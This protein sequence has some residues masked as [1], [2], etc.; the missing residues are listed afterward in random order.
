MEDRRFIISLVIVLIGG[1]VIGGL[2]YYRMKRS[3]E[4]GM[5]A[6]RHVLSEEELRKALQTLTAPTQEIPSVS[7]K[8][9]QS[10]S[11]PHIPSRTSPAVAEAPG[12]TAAPAKTPI[13][14]EVIKSL[15]A[16]Q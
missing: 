13:P 15:T 5:P 1:L 10:V 8:A 4:R 12:G 2:V 11:V 16:P 7:K 3:G 14:Q 6:E 9:M